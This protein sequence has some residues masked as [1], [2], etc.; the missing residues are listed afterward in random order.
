MSGERRCTSCD[1]LSPGDTYECPHC[2]NRADA[3]MGLYIVLFLLIFAAF[4]YVLFFY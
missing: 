4:I 3:Y 1:R 2:S